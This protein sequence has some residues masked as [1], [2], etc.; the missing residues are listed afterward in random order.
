MRDGNERLPPEG[1]QKQQLRHGHEA[2]LM[3]HRRVRGDK[4]EVEKTRRRMKEIAWRHAP[5]S[6]RSAG[7]RE[8]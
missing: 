6:A 7:G 5:P 4:K 8:Y 1:Q 3:I 2:E